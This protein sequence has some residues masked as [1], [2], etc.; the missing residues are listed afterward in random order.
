MGLCNGYLFSG[1]Y[2]PGFLLASG[3]DPVSE[4]RADLLAHKGSSRNKEKAPH[5]H[6][7]VFWIVQDVMMKYSRCTGGILG[8]ATAREQVTVW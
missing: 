8:Q 2:V 6:S 3:T 1:V 7:E 5:F 4:R